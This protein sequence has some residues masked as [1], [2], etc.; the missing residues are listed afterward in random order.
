MSAIDIE[1][2]TARSLDR[3]GLLGSAAMIALLGGLALWAAITPISGAVVAGGSVVVDGGVRRVQHQEGGIVREILVRNDAAVEAGQTLVVLD[4]TSV[5]AN[6]AVIDAQLGEAYVRQARLLA[7]AGG[8][9]EMEWT[10]ELDALPNMEHNRVLFAAEDR[11][12]QSRAAGLSTQVAQLGEQIVQLENQVAGLHAQRDAVVAQTEILT[13]Q[14]DRL[15]ALLSQGLVE[16]SRVS[17]LRR[18]I[19]QLDGERARITTEIAR[20]NAATA[21]R[22]LQ[23]SQVEESYQ[24]EV[25]GQLQET[26]QQIAELEQQ[27][28]AAQDRFDRLVIRAPIA[29]VVHQM[30][31]ATLGGIAAA[32]DTLMQI[33]PQ[34]DEIMVDV[35]INPLDIDKLAAEQS[36]TLRLSSFNSRS[37]P[38]LLG[39][40]DRISPDLTRDSASGTQFYLVR[41][42][43]PTD[44]LHKLPETA[45]LI[46]G[47]PVEAFF[48]TGEKTVLSYLTKP[49]MDQLNLAFRED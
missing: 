5:A 28:V 24:S 44:E 12:R 8:A 14:L 17:D 41:V 18:Q 42:R 9:T 30:Q 48:A 38:E 40:V 47:M 16:A 33:V 7:E 36:V 3:H 27:R 10:S 34:D 39:L 49:V 4:G 1:Y 35:R 29:G 37:T 22:R 15:S 2:A 46:P 13:E 26:G 20:G 32:G 11:L 45:R 23:I 43:L 6:M 19:A 31:V 25:L 21:E